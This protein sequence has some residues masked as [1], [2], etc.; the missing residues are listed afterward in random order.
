MSCTINL[1]IP[2]L[3]GISG[4]DY[5][6][7][8]MALQTTGFWIFLSYIILNRTQRFGNCS[9]SKT[10]CFFRILDSVTSPETQELQ[11]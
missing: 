10:L 11:L 5:L 4:A 1:G 2:V 8:H 7:R 9:L 3:G 6:C